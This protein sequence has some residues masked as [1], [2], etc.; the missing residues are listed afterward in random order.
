[1]CP[2]RKMQQLMHCGK[3]NWSGQLEV[4]WSKFSIA[5]YNAINEPLTRDREATVNYKC[6]RKL[7]AE[8]NLEDS[9]NVSLERFGLFSKWFGPIKGSERV[10]LDN[11][12]T[13]LAAIWFHGDIT[14]QQC[15]TYL[16]SFKKGCWMV[17]TSTTEPEK[18]P[19]TL[20]KFNKHG[21]VDHQRI[22]V[23]TKGYYSHIKYKTTQK[24]NRGPLLG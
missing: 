12:S 20:S 21:K 4:P 13:I 5:F 16:S 24:K 2:L 18:T 3:K 10:I 9:Q 22:F 17:R 14:R 19:F 15:E 6:L 1:M 11:V 7:V 23:G 8:G